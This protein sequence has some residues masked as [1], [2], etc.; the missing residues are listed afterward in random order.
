MENIKVPQD[1]SRVD[2][3]KMSPLHSQIHKELKEAHDSGI[4][5]I[6]AQD[7]PTLEIALSFPFP[8]LVYDSTP[9]MLKDGSQARFWIQEDHAAAIGDCL[10]RRDIFNFQLFMTTWKD[11]S[12]SIFVDKLKTGPGKISRL[13][14]HHNSGDEFT[15]LEAK[16]L[17]QWIH[18]SQVRALN[19]Q[20]HEFD[21][22]SIET[23]VSE[24]RALKNSTLQ[25]AVVVPHD[26]EREDVSIDSTALESFV[27]A[28]RTIDPMSDEVFSLL[29]KRV[30]D[31][32]TNR[33]F[34]DV[35]ALCTSLLRS[36][37]M[38]AEQAGW[39]ADYRH[40]ALFFIGTERS[41]REALR[42]LMKPEMAC[43]PSPRNRL[44]MISTSAEMANQLDEPQLT[45]EMVEL[46]LKENQRLSDPPE[47][48]QNE[49]RCRIN[50]L[51]F[52]NIDPSIKESEHKIKVIEL[53]RANPEW[54]ETIQVPPEIQSALR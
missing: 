39:F 8:I 9:V 38:T 19:L 18:H 42:L 40:R 48:E 34:H 28:N 22:G 21:A 44:W 26:S 52:K 51:H 27:A 23:L 10:S 4:L 5:V 46:Y 33:E 2:F 43:E 37:K 24:L 53:L 29:M 1:L 47:R 50:A 35:E 30:A 25:E 41:H 13:S 54:T 16:G 15:T 31:T 6:F 49:V 32:F 45:T 3:K 17:A 20:C 11:D 36:Y 12:M 14:I 7:F